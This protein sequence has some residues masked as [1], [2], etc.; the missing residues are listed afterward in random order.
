MGWW[1]AM[2]RALD[3][4]VY[5]LTLAAV[6]CWVRRT[7]RSSLALLLLLAGCC[8]VLALLVIA[9]DR[10][11]ILVPV[12]LFLVVLVLTYGRPRVGE[13]PDRAEGALLAIFLTVISM[14]GAGELLGALASG[15]A[16]WPALARVGVWWTYGLTLC[17]Y[18]TPP[19]DPP[20]P[21]PKVRAVA[22]PAGG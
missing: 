4:W 5:G 7:G 22:A 6:A 14:G 11:P 19:V 20:P 1:G 8:G 16:W 12:L 13:R 2:L 3:E 18:R 17:V 15:Q 9:A 10:D 21:V